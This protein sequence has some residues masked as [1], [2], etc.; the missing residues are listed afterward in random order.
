MATLTNQQINLTYPGLIKTTD[1]LG[2]DPTTLKQLT[3]GIGGSI[4]ISV[5]QIETKF[6][7]GSVVDL[8][9]VTVNGLPT[10]QGGLITGNG[11]DAMQ[12]AAFLSPNAANASGSGAIALGNSSNSSGDNSISVGN[13][14]TAGSPNGIRIGADNST[15]GDG[16]ISIGNRGSV[17]GNVSVGI[18]FEASV[19]GGSSI[20]MATTTQSFGNVSGGGTVALIPGEFAGVMQNAN[21]IIIGS[22]SDNRQRANAENNISIGRNTVANGNNAIA[23]GTDSNTSQD[24]AVAIGAG[25]S[26]NIN[27][28]VSV[29]ALEIQNSGDG[30]I[31]YSPN[32][33]AYRITVTDGGLLTATAV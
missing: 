6:Q 23:L 28:C 9:N 8:T 3:D 11:P 25:I 16:L 21:M 12:S 33:T 13:Y 17:T 2:V 30:L 18:G 24:G 27:S 20:Y 22:S 14:G 32:Q 7:E 19:S 1:N 5:S 29:N 26:A 4:P 15:G 10:A 31:M